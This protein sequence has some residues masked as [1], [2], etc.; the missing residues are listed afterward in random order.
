MEENV[1]FFRGWRFNRA[2]GLIEGLY[3][4]DPMRVPREHCRLVEDDEGRLVR[5]EE[6][7]GDGD[8]PAIKVFGYS[9]EDPRILEALDYNPDGSLR[10]IHRYIYDLDGPMVD[11]VEL[12]G[13]GTP[14]GHVVSSWEN[15]LET[16]E[17]AYDPAENVVAKHCYEYDGA[18]NI[19]RET[20]YR[21][22]GSLQGKRE[23]DYDERGNV[24]EKRWYSPDGSLQTRYVHTFDEQDLLA[25]SVLYGGDGAERGRMQF[26][27]DEVG[28]PLSAEP[29]TSETP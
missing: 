5:L 29:A 2:I 28:N 22:D 27:Y 8:L 16:S 9:P 19:I 18:G 21:G 1:R 20:V 3:E 23:L 14:R 25:T 15:G 24:V 11:R 10:L 13:S 6:Y 7:R 17:T 12:D 26:A 4:L